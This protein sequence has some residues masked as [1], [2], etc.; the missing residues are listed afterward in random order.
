VAIPFRK[1]EA[2]NAFAE[3]LV[4]HLGPAF[5]VTLG[6]IDQN[7]MLPTPEFAALLEL[8]ADDPPAWPP[9]V[10]PASET[11]SP[12]DPTPRYDQERQRLA[13]PTVDGP[14]L[15]PT[16]AP[17]GDGLLVS[18]SRALADAILAAPPNE[19]MLPQPANLFMRIQPHPA[20][21]AFYNAAM[22]FVQLGVVRN[23]DPASF[24]ALLSPWLE[25]SGQ[26]R[27]IAVSAAHEEGAIRLEME[28]DMNP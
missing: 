1:T 8:T 13:I 27:S 25:R 14:S 3:N 9:A 21:E 12:E 17:Y 18:T 26:I 24:D 15:Q 23:C 28:L 5:R 11:Y 2:W 6:A 16:L 22:Q 4:R 20:L 10:S 7:A 19:E